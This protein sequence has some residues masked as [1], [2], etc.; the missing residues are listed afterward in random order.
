LSETKDK[1]KVLADAGV[2]DAGAQGFVHFIEGIHN[3]IK[4]GELTREIDNK[5]N[6]REL[7][8][9]IEEHS[10]FRYCSEFL[11]K[12]SNFDTDGIKEELKC[13]G[14]S[15]IVASTGTGDTRYLRIHIHT[16]TPKR[17]KCL[18]QSIGIIENEKID[19]MKS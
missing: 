17:I 8:R 12:G 19:D 4:T 10:K 16:D 2:V 7:P 6:I 9:E 5:L 1:L 15:L 18:A 13:H 3:F 14:D 11:V